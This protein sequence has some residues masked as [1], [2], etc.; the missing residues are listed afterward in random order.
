M[1]KCLKIVLIITLLWISGFFYWISLIRKDFKLP[2]E[3]DSII[4]LTGGV[5]RLDEALRLLNEKK[6]SEMLISGVDKKTKKHELREVSKL[7][8]SKDIKNLEH[9]IHLG[10]LA[11]DTETNAKEAKEWLDK[12]NFKSLI[13]VTSDYHMPRS[14][15]IFS[16]ILKDKTIYPYSVKSNTINLDNWWKSYNILRLIFIE[17]NKFIYSSFYGFF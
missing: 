2:N 15:I 7:F 13:L 4:V 3:A 1:I 9:M 16:K 14:L 6:S 8:S 10:Y 12:N 5:G 17:Y 11:I